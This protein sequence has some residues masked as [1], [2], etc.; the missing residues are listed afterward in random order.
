MK[1]TPCRMAGGALFLGFII[2]F[3][4][5]NIICLEIVNGRSAFVFR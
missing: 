3:T 2:K 5:T 4:Q 1:S